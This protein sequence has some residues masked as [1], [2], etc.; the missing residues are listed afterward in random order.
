MSSL[1]LL[2]SQGLQVFFIIYLWCVCSH[3]NIFCVYIIPSFVQ[4]VCACEC[5]TIKI[6]RRSRLSNLLR[7]LTVDLRGL[8]HERLGRGPSDPN[9][10]QPQPRHQ[11]QR[12]AREKPLHLVV[13]ATTHCGRQFAA[14]VVAAEPT[15]PVRG[16]FEQGPVP[17]TRMCS[18]KIGPHRTHTLKG[19]SRMRKTTTLSPSHHPASAEYCLHP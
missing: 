19:T 10:P 8:E 9:Q 3:H 17:C 11:Q 15:D 4:L 7:I 12:Q 16:V 2:K 1:N 13:R 18:T 6:T 14:V 5:N